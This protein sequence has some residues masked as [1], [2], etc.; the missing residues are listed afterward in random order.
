MVRTTLFVVMCFVLIGSASAKPEF[1]DRFVE[2][3]A[4]KSSLVNTKCGICHTSAPARNAYGKQ[5]KD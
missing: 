2:T 5:L 4:P 1:Y 3:Y